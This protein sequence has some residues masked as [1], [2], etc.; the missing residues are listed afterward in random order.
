MRKIPLCP[1]LSR[2]SKTSFIPLL[3]SQN[4]YHL[5]NIFIFHAEFICVFIFT[6]CL[7]CAILVF[8]DVAC[9][10]PDPSPSRFRIQIRIINAW[11]ILFTSLSHSIYLALLLCFPSPFPL[12]LFLLG[13][14]NYGMRFNK[15]FVV[16]LPLHF[17]RPC[18]P[19]SRSR[20]RLCCVACVTFVSM[21][22]VYTGQI[23]N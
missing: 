2:K 18:M 4:T 1:G 6:L 9:V 23:K 7:S 10:T 22:V 19:F 17:G 14:P 20:S 12:Q 15:D 13:T 3:K 5:K 11:D 21:H 8:T 16:F